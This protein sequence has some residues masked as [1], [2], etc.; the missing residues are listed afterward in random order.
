MRTSEFDDFGLEVEMKPFVDAIRRD[1]PNAKIFTERCWQESPDEMWYFEEGDCLFAREQPDSFTGTIDLNLYFMPNL[2]D[3]S[4][5]QARVREIKRWVVVNFMW[6]PFVNDISCS[7]AEGSD[8]V[9][10]TFTLWRRYRLVK[11]PAPKMGTLL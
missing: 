9:Q 11:P 2:K 3:L 4:K 10:F 6:L 8:S 1:F 5:V 7:Q